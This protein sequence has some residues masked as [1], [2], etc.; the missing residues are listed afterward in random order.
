VIQVPDPP[1]IEP[2]PAAPE[3]APKLEV[4]KPDQPE[5]AD[6][7]SPAPGL[8]QPGQNRPRLR[9][10]ELPVLNV[11]KRA[12]S[13]L[14]VEQATATGLG[15][16]G[17]LQ[18]GNV[19]LNARP[20][21]VI[22]AAVDSLVAGGGSQIVGD[23]YSGGAGPALPSSPGNRGSTLELLSDPKGV[24]FRPYLIQVLAAVRRNWYAVIP[25]SA[26]LGMSRGRVAIQFIISRD[27]GV[28]KLVI[29]GSANVN[30]LDHAAVAGISASVPFQR[31]P[32]E[33]AGNEIRLQFVFLYN[34]KR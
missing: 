31:L 5:V 21:E 30:A 11:P 24:D 23:G 2:R 14:D 17:D 22:Q 26:R 4:E 6:A 19:R 10:D 33:F 15:R 28:P 29:A 16:D 25:E 7:R 20:D 27:G 34:V 12:D 18:I 8:T 3:P 13:K 32:V 9:P 1:Q